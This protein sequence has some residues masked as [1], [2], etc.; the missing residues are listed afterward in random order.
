[1][2]NTRLEASHHMITDGIVATLN[3]ATLTEK[4]QD[5]P[6]FVKKLQKVLG[7]KLFAPAAR[8]D[9]KV[10]PLINFLKKSGT[11]TQ[12]NLPTANT[13]SMFAFVN[14]CARTP[15]SSTNVSSFQHSCAKQY[16]TAYIQHTQG[17]SPCWTSAKMCG[18]HTSIARSSRWHKLASISQ[19][20]V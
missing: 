5:S 17:Q 14:M 11:G 19:S 2:T 1:M 6:L 18:L 13:N 20:K 7:I 3:Q 4:E 16:W 9:R 8:K 10:S 12:S 15:C